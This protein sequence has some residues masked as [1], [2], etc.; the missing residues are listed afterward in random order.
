MKHLLFVL[1]LLAAATP[2]YGQQPNC[3]YASDD[4]VAINDQPPI[5]TYCPSGKNG[6]SF[7]NTRA[8]TSQ[9]YCVDTNTNPPSHY[10]PIHH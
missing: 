4:G 10:D 5:A 7:S 3:T 2:S 9:E 1:V 6:T 8:L